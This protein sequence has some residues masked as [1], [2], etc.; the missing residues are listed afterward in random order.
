[1]PVTETIDK[2]ADD[3]GADAFV[4]GVSGHRDLVPADIPE[5]RRQIEIVFDSFGAAYSNRSFEL[6]SPLAEGADRLAAEAALS[7]GI[8]LAVPLPMAQ[9]DYEQDFTADESLAEFRRMLGAAT[10]HW[11][12]G[13]GGVANLSDAEK[14]NQRYA[15][16]G[17]YI[18]RRSHLLILLWDGLASEKIGGTAWVKTRREFWMDRAQK[19]GSELSPPGYL[20]T[21]QIVTPRQRATTTGA[22]RPQIAIVGDLPKIG[23]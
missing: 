9:S 3:N 10:T 21:I 14:R 18:A 17:E 19:E 7:R 5:L 1:M 6:L 8:Q 16:V 15:A 22:A 13:P 4:F 20:P 2:R 12:L 11:E 23:S